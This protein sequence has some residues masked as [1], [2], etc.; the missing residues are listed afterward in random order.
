MRKGP[1]RQA[2]LD[3]FEAKVDR[4]PLYGPQGDCWRWTGFTYPN[5][6]GG[7]GR[8]GHRAGNEK[9]H[10]VAFLLHHGRLPSVGKEVCHRCDVR[11]CV[12]W[13]HLFEGT[14]AENL[15]DM[16]IKGDVDCESISESTTTMRNCRT[17][18]RVR[19]ESRK[20]LM[21]LRQNDTA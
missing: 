14:R 5:G 13:A 1:P 18:M 8:G 12:N 10:R 7:M 17:A 9:A 6:Y 4:T 19:S 3:R 2:L 11:D 16:T 21:M 20:V 15:A